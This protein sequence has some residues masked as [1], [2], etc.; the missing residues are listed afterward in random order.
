MTGK[1]VWD[2]KVHNLILT[3]CV[4]C[5]SVLSHVDQRHAV[6]HVASCTRSIVCH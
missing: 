1:L 4:A 2:E 5:R 6:L 3:K